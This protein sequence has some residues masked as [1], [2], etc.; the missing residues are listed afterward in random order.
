MSG[1]S[2]FPANGSSD[3]SAPTGF[4]LCYRERKGAP[5]L[6]LGRNHHES[7]TLRAL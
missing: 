3:H 2:H 1:V 5:P 4:T 6:Y 7:Q